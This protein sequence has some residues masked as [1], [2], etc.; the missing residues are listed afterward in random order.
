MI[1]TT[2]SQPQPWTTLVELARWRAAQQPDQLAYTFLTDDQSTTDYLSY[3]ALDRQARAIA[4]RLQQLDMPGQRAVLLYPP[5]LAYIAAFFGCLYAGVTAI[6][7]YPPTSAR[8]DRSLPQ[9]LLAIVRD[10]QPRIALTT[11]ATVELGQ[12]LA[13]QA[14]DLQSL[15]WLA[16]DTSLPEV[17]EQWQSPAIDAHTLAFLQYTSGSTST[18]KGVMLSHA[19]LLHNLELIRHAFGH[20]PES[21]GVIW[22]PPYHDMGLI[23][24]ILQPLYAGFPVT[25]MSPLAF[26]Q[27][28]V[29]WLQAISQFRGTTSGGPNF[30]YDLCVRKI[31]SEQRRSLDLSSWT[32][33]FNGAEPV[34]AET[35][36]RFATTFA[37]C[38]FRREAFYPCY[39]LAEAT[40]IVAGGRIA[41]PPTIADFASA[42]LEQHQV[43]AAANEP[44]RRLVSSGAALLDQQ[45]AIVDPETLQACAA[46]RVGEI[47]VAGPSVAQGYWGQPEAT[48]HTF[49]ATIEGRTGRFLRTGDLGLLH[50]GEL[51]VAGRLKDLLIIRGRNHYPQDIE[52]T[53]E[54]SHSALRPGAIA[55]FTVE[56]D[57]EERLVVVCEVERQSRRVA[58]EDVAAAIRQAIAEHHELQIDTVVLL[59]PGGVPKT[60]SGK[61][62]RSATRQAFL[63][64]T[65]DALGSSTLKT[66]TE[67]ATDEPAAG[68]LLDQ[69]P[70]Q[71]QPWLEHYLRGLVANALRIAPAAVEPEQPLSSLGLD[72]LMAV[73][74]Q[75]TI[76]TELRAIIPMARL[77]EGVTIAQLAADILT[78]VESG[79]SPPIS[80][81]EP[82][83]DHPL[84]AGQRAIWFLYQ[85]APESTAYNI[86]RAAR[87]AGDIDLPALE[88]AFQRLIER[89]ST[90]R[91]TLIER[92]DQPVQQVHAEA[93]LAFQVEDATGW[94]DTQL[95]GRLSA[96]TQ[97]PFDLDHGPLL[98][99]N[100]FA[101]PG[102]YVLL[103]AIHHSVADLWSL[104]VLTHEAGLLYTAERAGRDA[105]LPPLPVSYADYARWQADLLASVEG[106][107]LAAYWRE[108]LIPAG[109]P[110]QTTLDLPTDRPR[111]PL[112]TYR[113]ATLA[114]ALDAEL[115]RQLK[116]L[117]LH[118]HTT[119][120]TTLQAAFHTLLYRYTG[121]RDILVGSPTAG[122]TRAEWA[123][124]IGYF[125]N[126][127]PLRATFAPGLAFDALLAQMRETVLGAFAHGDYPL[128][129]IVEA[130][131]PE[132]DPSRQPLFQVV[133]ALQAAQAQPERSLAAFAFG[134]PGAQIQLGDLR[135]ESIALE[136]QIAQFD[137]SVMLAESDGGLV[138]SWEYNLDLFDA[139]TIERMARHFQTLLASI[140]A[141][142]SA[143]IDRLPLLTSAEAQQIVIDWNRSAAEYPPEA[144]IHG[145]IEAHSERTPEAVA[146]VFEQQMLSYAEL[147]ARANQ[148]AH[149]LRTQGIGPESLVALCVERSPEMIVGI[150]GILKAG[151]AY[152]PLDPTYPAE[153][154]QYMLSHSRAAMILT[155]EH[156]VAQLPEH[157][158]QVFRLDADWHTLAEQPA[159]NPACAVLPEELAYVIFTSGS[160]GRPKGVACAHRGVLN[161]LADFERRQP[162][163]TGDR[164]SLW[165]SISFDVSVYE[166]FSALTSGATLVIA[167]EDVRPSSTAFLSWLQ[168]QTITSAYVPAFMLNDLQTWLEQGNSLA[169]RRLLVGVEPIAEPLLGAITAR[170][171]EL[172]IINAYG[173]TE[174]TVCA[175]VYSVPQAVAPQRPTPIGRPVQN[176]Q[177]YLLD[178]QLQ[179]VPVGVPGELYAGGTGLAYGYFN[180][181]DLTAERFIPDPF[182]SEPGARLYKT[183]DLAC[184]LADG[185]IKFLGRIDHQVKIRGFRVELGE[186]ET[187]LAQHPDVR[188]AVVVTREDARGEKRIVAYV[189]GEQRNKRTKEQTEDQEPRTKNLELRTDNVTALLAAPE[190]PS[191]P[192]AMGEGGRGGEGLRQFLAQRL[193]DYMLPSAFVLLDALPLTPSG[194]L[195]RQAL[196]APSFERPAA[197]E[198]MNTPRTPTEEIVAS[199][200]ADVLDLHRIG[201]HDNFFERGGHSLLATQVVS[202]V[203]DVFQVELPLRTLFESPTIAGWTE[204]IEAA[205]QATP[206]QAPAIV[207]VDHDAPLPL[208]FAQQRLWILDQLEPGTATYNIPG[209]L[210]LRGALDV[211]ALERS[212]EAIV[213]RHAVL[214]TT[215]SQ[216]DLEPDGVAVQ[217][218]DEWLS[219]PLMQL[220]LRT[221]PEPQR[222]E[223]AGRLIFE[224]SQQPFDLMF[225]PLLRNTLLTLD[226]QEHVLLITMHHIITDGWSLSVFVRELAVL[227]QAFVSG[228]ESP[229][230]PLP[231]Q[232]ADYAVWQRGW[233]QGE[234]LESQLSYWRRQ[235][236]NTVPLAL[237]TDRPR[238]P[239]RTFR[240][241]RQTLTIDLGLAEQLHVFSRRN[242][243][244]LFMTLLTAFKL[245]MQRYSGQRDIVVGTPIAG[246]TRAETESL[247]GLFL[248][249]LALRTD[250]DGD[251]GFTELLGRVRATCLDAYAHQDVPFEKLLDELQPERNLSHTPLFQVFFNMLNLPDTQLKLPGLDVELI[252]PPE[253]G[254]KFDLTLYVEE[255][256]AGIFCDLVYNADLFAAERM[257][258]L[259]DQ[260]QHVLTQA[261]A[262]PAQ[263]IGAISLVT[264]AAR[265]LLPDP[266]APLDDE[267]VGFAHVMFQ[268]Q[269]TLGPERIAVIDPVTQWS[270]AE[271]EERSNRL[272]HALLASG[273]ERGERVAIYGQRGAALVWALLGV[274]KAGAAFTILDPS[275]PAARLIDY[276]QLA[277]L[278]AWIQ[279]AAAGD[280]PESLARYLTTLGLRCSIELPREAA[281]LPDDLA[282]LP[283][284]T[285]D[286]TLSPD[287]LAYVAFTSGSTGRPK[288]ILGT[289]RPLAHFLAWHSATFGFAAADRFSMLSGLAH[290]PLLRDIFTPLSVGATLCIPDPEALS[291]PGYLAAWAQESA[292][293]VMHLTP[294]L[295][296]LLDV[297]PRSAGGSR[298]DALLP[299]L[300][301]VFFGGD[302][303]TLHDVERARTIAPGA[304]V[305]NFYGATETPQGIAY[306]VIEQPEAAPTADAGDQ[307]KALVPLGRGIADVQLL[308]LNAGRQLAGVGEL[309]E[310]YVRSPY[311]A[312][313]Y[314][315][316]PSRTGERFLLNP[317]TG[318]AEDRV[319]R[320]ADL[321]RYLPDGSVVFAGRADH[322]V[323]IRGFRIEPAEVK[324]AIERHPDVREVVV[325]AREDMPGEKR[326]VAYVVGE[327]PRTKNQ[328]P[329][330]EQRNKG[331][332][333]QST[334]FSP[335]PVATEAEAGRDSGKGG[336]G[337]E[338]LKHENLEP[339]TKNLNDEPDGS[340]FSVLGSADLRSFVQSLLPGYMVPAVFVVLDAL[341]LTPNGKIDERALPRPEDQRAQQAQ[342]RPQTELERTIASV[343]QSVLHIERLGVDDNFFDLG[344]SSVHIMQVHS[345]LR[346]RLG[347]DFPVVELFKYPTIGALARW[348]SQDQTLPPSFEEIDDRV[349]KQLE[350]LE[351]Q[352]RLRPDLES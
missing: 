168:H 225:G 189:V 76:E 293:T 61:I 347:R 334:E 143:A 246:R 86:V 4:A 316:D 296:H 20:T 7:A 261:I 207:P 205:R 194:K 228:A 68:A 202:R 348:L 221:L 13:A 43:V 298:G 38:G 249:T 322:Q 39:G 268:Q 126:L 278:R 321:G 258:A 281:I 8:L 69:P 192:I 203:R 134:R 262:Q 160:T 182:G 172:R 242:G 138:G 25:L 276:L 99:I 243:A 338:G 115:T 346:D 185:N 83:G 260:F 288:A 130:A 291:V 46:D 232:Y 184:Y 167:S 253:L 47:W 259:L 71:R 65:L 73:E 226:D 199:I 51:F 297:A 57:D 186:I 209:A 336:Q 58:I 193:P 54:R 159:T 340:R 67:A 220:D 93:R 80:A 306:H 117:A 301:Y 211:F 230:P 14:V 264:P 78:Q 145:L 75:H 214:R 309:G 114:F 127:L 63:S 286:H 223:E 108:Q 287:D 5:G 308:V 102:D 64:E 302:V 128:S 284:T 131:Q 271:L 339:R 299:Q 77:L 169:L 32:V 219:A 19:N 224:E 274:L 146:V 187:T 154:L 204:Q 198:A 136:Q 79:G 106:E 152:V 173:P 6:P 10:A 178:A 201:I 195:D 166:L 97:R 147:N 109:N 180:R 85:L 74:L 234:V 2:V 303:L 84:S 252:A 327:E 351:W 318:R 244:T 170:L 140:V 149:Y 171:P 263:P 326:L 162:L 119:L 62:Q 55:A 113:G 12:A 241:A 255:Q 100:V 107:R 9:R 1:G 34:R 26:L 137:L 323:K 266:T 101:R 118:A 272:A 105:P 245:L 3:A 24:G 49:A 265:A 59:R 315:G 90:L 98:R 311:L 304:A 155:Q 300:R 289:H 165:G 310:I 72:S 156:L 141:R 56:Q 328:E 343:W 17:A 151:A 210:R 273:V 235:L 238:P 142:P 82:L 294:A 164:G 70:E 324:A 216:S 37:E 307:S 179:P 290:D 28:P 337:D 116:A 295:G 313:G 332:K 305:V 124:L 283:E 91:T 23:G 110:A 174:T 89:H 135:L 177:V 317:L 132:R 197:D 31:T 196:P 269:A 331:T 45:I 213:R 333:E 217:T 349:R 191:S 15:S 33:A 53:V 215:F 133:F 27:Q 231:I 158:A 36:D 181:P 256:A 352:R 144:T 11:S 270:Y 176:M 248:N 157:A 125:V 233:M 325:V 342:S 282:L 103:L 94:S 345:Q 319:Y 88:R 257:A 227:Y 123:S 222:E 112:Q 50:A 18:P 96:E 35:I 150:I 239:V 183:G 52:A 218:I 285:P 92:A 275:Y 277:G 335:S 30:A 236:A 121:Q 148:L 48:R 161:L 329:N 139:A 29:R 95:E 81:A 120:Y 254:A 212:L 344:G 190:T 40:L 312:Q 44:S 267:F 41:A 279:L 129:L 16:T 122:R 229:L 314:G 330:G 240:S 60:T 21:Q 200:W 341:P 111:P 104:D 206:D 87:L 66:T 280:P 153:R 42:A 350:A 188:D 251:P 250:L 320:T 237:P 208:S 163:T 22:L 247:I 292:I 175:T